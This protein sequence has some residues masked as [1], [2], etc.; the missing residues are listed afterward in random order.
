MVFQ[1]I[2]NT[3]MMAWIYMT[4]FI[5]Q[6]YFLPSITFHI[7][8]LSSFQFSCEVYRD[9]FN[10]SMLWLNV[11]NVSVHF[12]CI[13]GK[14]RSILDQKLCMKVYHVDSCPH[15]GHSGDWRVIAETIVLLHCP[16][17]SDGPALKIEEL[18]KWVTRSWRPQLTTKFSVAAATAG[19]ASAL[20]EIF[21]RIP[22]S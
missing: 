20:I 4:F 1:P 12:T 16:P 17:S 3:I 9:I 19:S 15:N 22:T 21:W 5:I 2:L 11:Q 18:T 6:I 13:T 14:K 7:K 8:L 10:I